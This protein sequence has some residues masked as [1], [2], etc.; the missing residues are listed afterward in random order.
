MT[1]FFFLQNVRKPNRITIMEGLGTDIPE[2]EQ[3]AI[4]TQV[5]N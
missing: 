3:K 4:L 1:Y 2:P 5:Y